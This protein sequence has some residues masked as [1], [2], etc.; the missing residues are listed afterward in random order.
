MSSP[1]DARPG[2]GPAR[3]D[4]T[5]RVLVITVWFEGPG[6]AGFRARV[7]AGPATGGDVVSRHVT[8]DPAGVSVA[9]SSWLA[10]LLRPEQGR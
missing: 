8:T 6:P 2:S 3:C 9:V 5:A 4:P 7:S 1:D 10:E